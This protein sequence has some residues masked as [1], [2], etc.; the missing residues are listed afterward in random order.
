MFTRL[1]NKN[2]AQQILF[3]KIK[4]HWYLIKQNLKKSRFNLRD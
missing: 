3:A 2:C 4:F 1:E